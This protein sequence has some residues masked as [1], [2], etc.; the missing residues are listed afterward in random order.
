MRE[1]V[2]DLIFLIG[3]LFKGIDGI[4]EVIGGVALLLISPAQVLYGARLVTAEDLAED[5]R[6]PLAQLVLTGA[7]TW[8]PTQPAS[9]RPT[10]WCTVW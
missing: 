2:W 9:R 4:V 10:C 7:S 8:T 5:P 6:D 3:V 1:R